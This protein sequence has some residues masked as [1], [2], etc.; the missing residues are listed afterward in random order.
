MTGDPRVHHEFVFVY[1][2]ELGQRE[3]ELHA[4]SG[5]AFAGLL[6]QL[7]HPGLEL[8]AA[9]EL[10][11]PVNLRQAV[12]DDVLLRRVDRASERQHPFVHPVGPHPCPSRFP[13][14]RLHHLV[15]DTAEQE[16]ISLLDA[17]GRSPMQLLVG[18]AHAVV[19][20]AIQGDVDGVSEW[21]HRARMVTAVRCPNPWSRA[22]PAASGGSNL[23]PRGRAVAA[24]RFGFVERLVSSPEPSVIVQR[25]LGLSNRQRSD[26]DR[27]PAMRRVGGVSELK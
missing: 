22:A 26:R 7:P 15:G 2:A 6:F 1:Q 17:L 5:K 3:R 11:V 16:G 18:D 23:C 24:I 25:Q 14:C 19:Y 9:D 10:G 20:A 27:D 4:S 12:G 13:P 21:S 8:V